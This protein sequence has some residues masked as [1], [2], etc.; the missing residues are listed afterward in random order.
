MPRIPSYRLHKASGQAVVWLGRDVYLGKHGSQE[1]REKYHRFISEWLASGRRL[2]IEK[3][4]DLTVVELCAAY[5]RHAKQH[6]RKADG[7]A[8]DTIH[9]VRQAIKGLKRLY[10]S[11]PVQDFG[12]RCLQTVQQ[13]WVSAGLCRKTVNQYIAY[14][15]RIF[16]WGVAQELVPETVYRAL[17]TLPGLRAGQSEAA[18]PEP[19]RPVQ[20]DHIDAVRPYVSRQVWALIQ[21]QLATG[22]R[23]GELVGL[24]PIDLDT[25]GPV[26]TA[27]LTDHKTS[28]HGREKLIYFGPRAQAIVRQ[29][30]TDRPVDAYLFSPRE[31][32]RER[33]AS[34]STHRR[35]GQPPSARKTAITVGARYTSDSYRRAIARAC[36][37]V[38][39]A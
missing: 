37:L 39:V 38:A 22:A 20:Q 21:L 6:Y 5:W 34:A 2:P 36:E 7:T 18:D 26:W 31:A 11:V 19:K 17:A 30:M 35:P 9:G 14:A 4:P 13:R 10:G 15:K 32:V 23:G 16:K 29:F 27:T 28:H 33:A 12:P 25:S 3:R 24:R 1:S 8:T